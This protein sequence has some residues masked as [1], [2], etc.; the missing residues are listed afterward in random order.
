VRTLGIAGISKSV[1]SRMCA[2]LY[3]CVRTS[4]ERRLDEHRHRGLWLDAQVVKVREPGCTMAMPLVVAIAVKE[5][6]EREVFGLDVGPAA[7]NPLWTGFLRSL[8]A[9]GL[10]GVVLVTSDAHVGL[11][12]TDQSTLLEAT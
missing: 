10:S 1:V 7:G 3:R 5:R 12:E 6:G 9:R 4:W 8:V 11:R 2:E